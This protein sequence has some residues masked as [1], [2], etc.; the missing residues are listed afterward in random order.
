MGKKKLTIEVEEAV[1]AIERAKEEIADVA[2]ALESSE[3]EEQPEAKPKRQKTNELA[4]KVLG[5]MRTLKV[6][7]IRETTST[8]L[9]DKLHLNKETG[10]DK[11]RR[12]MRHLAKEGKVVITE[13]KIGEKRKQYIYKLAE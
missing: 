13:K 5:I 12:I 2:E 8:I 3:V 6:N 9:R 7:G 1:E 10:R 4:V 11:V